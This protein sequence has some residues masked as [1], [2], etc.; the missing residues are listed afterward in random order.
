MRIDALPKEMSR[1]TEN[2]VKKRGEPQGRSTSPL[3]PARASEA[4]NS[5][6]NK[7]QFADQCCLR[8]RVAGRPCEPFRILGSSLCVCL[9]WLLCCTLVCIA[10]MRPYLASCFFPLFLARS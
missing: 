7:S 6:E 2:T 10:S 5:R 8:I 1:E 4:T 3:Q 9:L